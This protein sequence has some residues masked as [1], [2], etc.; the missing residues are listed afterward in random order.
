[1]DAVIIN[2]K[3]FGGNNASASVLAPHIVE[4]MLAKRHGEETISKYKA[5]NEAVE[6]ASQEN[7][8]YTM[9]AENRTI[10]K[11]DHKVLGSESSELDSGNLTV[12]GLKREITLSRDNPYEDM[13]D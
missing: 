4:K 9:A 2:S 8:A 6:Q 1:M 5:R 7:D 12:T 13:C 11:N 10:Y 3:G